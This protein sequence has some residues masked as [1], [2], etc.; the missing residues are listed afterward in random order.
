M[1]DESLKK[2][3]ERQ[4]EEVEHR[5]GEVPRGAVLLTTDETKTCRKCFFGVMTGCERGYGQEFG[6]MSQMSRDFM[7]THVCDYFVEPDEDDVHQSLEAFC[8]KR[9]ALQGG[10]MRKVCDGD[11]DLEAQRKALL[12]NEEDWR[13]RLNK[14]KRLVEEQRES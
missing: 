12:K 5:M 4:R 14:I 13:K 8:R 6:S 10:I 1:I 3:A 7:L 2:D 9:D 11:F